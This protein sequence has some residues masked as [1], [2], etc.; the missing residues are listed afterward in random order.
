[1]IYLD[2]GERELNN[3]RRM[4][5]LFSEAT[6]RLM[7]RGFLVNSRLVPGGEHCEASWEQQIPFFMETLLYGLDDDG[8]A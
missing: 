3:H 2:Y 1:M 6:V 8:E 5:R 4:R 7:N